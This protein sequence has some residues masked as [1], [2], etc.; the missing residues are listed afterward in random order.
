M[1][2]SAC[3]NDCSR[4]AASPNV[5]ADYSQNG[6]RGDMKASKDGR[7]ADMAALLDAAAKDPTPIFDNANFGPLSPEERAASDRSLLTS[8]LKA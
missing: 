5:S 7:Y 4:S 6:A 2:L 1:T 3:R 8:G